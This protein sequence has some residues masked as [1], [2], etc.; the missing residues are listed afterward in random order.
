MKGSKCFCLNVKKYLV[1]CQV[2]TSLVCV[3]VCKLSTKKE[4][5]TLYCGCGCVCVCFID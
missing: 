1:L 2:L 5:S 3:C 4:L